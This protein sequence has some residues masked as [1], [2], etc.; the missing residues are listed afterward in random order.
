MRKEDDPLGSS[1]KDL[2]LIEQVLQSLIQGQSLFKWNGIELLY[3][4][5]ALVILIYQ[6]GLLWARRSPTKEE[7]EY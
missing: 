1:R 6:R 4:S 5:I 3:I 7:E 2:S